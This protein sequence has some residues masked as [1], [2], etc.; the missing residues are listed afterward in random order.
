[1]AIAGGH[2]LTLGSA[3]GAAAGAH[4]LVGVH[5]GD[6]MIA[7]AE[8]AGI[9]ARN[10]LP[11]AIRSVRESDAGALV[12]VTI[13]PGQPDVAVLVTAAARRA[14]DLRETLPVRLVAKAQACRLLAVR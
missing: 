1:V 10:I 14:L 9:S 8:T 13:A 6:L 4:V 11:G 7:L 12:L 2:R 3:T 5:A